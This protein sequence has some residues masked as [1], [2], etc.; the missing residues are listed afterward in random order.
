VKFLS[1]PGAL[2]FILRRKSLEGHLAGCGR[3]LILGRGLQIRNPGRITL[4]K[5]VIIS[6]RCVLDA[7]G[8]EHSRIIIGDGAFLSSG[9]V[10][11]TGGGPIEIGKGS[12][13]GGF[14]TLDG[15]TGLLLG[16]DVLVAAHA[17][18]SGGAGKGAKTVI[19][20]GCWLGVRARVTAGATIG[21][22]TIVGAHSV[23]GG[24]LPSLSVAY[25][26]PARAIR[27]RT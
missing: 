20:N 25:G 11:R 14:C 21:R 15:G 16:Q 6:D 3:G 22:D 23:V 27:S 13:I 17:N 10:L 1:L 24:D 26:N 7:G 9:T 18:L 12:S 4:G 19:G 2:G 8:G 5:G